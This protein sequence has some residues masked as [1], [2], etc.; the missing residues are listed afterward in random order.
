MVISSLPFF[1][2]DPPFLLKSVFLHKLVLIIL[3][4]PV[5]ENTQSFYLDCYFRQSWVDPRLS[6]NV[7]GV[8][9]LP[10]NWQFLTK[11]WKP[12]TFFLNGKKSKLHKI[13][14]GKE[15]STLFLIYQK[16][17]LSDTYRLQCNTTTFLCTIALQVPNRFLRIMPDGSISYSQRLTVN[18]NEKIGRGKDTNI[19]LSF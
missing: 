6:Y 12:D 11:I 9:Q 2:F 15:N 5:N 19:K 18:S 8:Q 16:C 4:G 3:Q 7:T 1:L 14:V 17:Y 10:M 13:T